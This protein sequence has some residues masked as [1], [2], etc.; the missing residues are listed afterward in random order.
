MHAHPSAERL[1]A[2]AQLTTGWPLDSPRDP[3]TT[4]AVLLRIRSNAPIR[5]ID[6]M[7]D[8][9]VHLLSS[10]FCHIKWFPGVFFFFCIKCTV[11]GAG[12][13]GSA[14]GAEVSGPWSF[15]KDLHTRQLSHFVEN[16]F[17]SLWDPASL[18]EPKYDSL[19][20]SLQMCK[21]TKCFLLSD[22]RVR[23][24]MLPLKLT[25]LRGLAPRPIRG[26][27]AKVV[28]GFEPPI[29]WFVVQSSRTPFL[30]HGV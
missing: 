22:C 3:I 16:P 4:A 21:T 19:T 8:S 26:S 20:L 29:I 7:L 2:C 30:I 27:V 28:P 18:A 6:R 10:E 24:C 25:W 14:G 9:Q 17:L 11:L 23:Y 12:K 13:A 1:L 15:K 5:L